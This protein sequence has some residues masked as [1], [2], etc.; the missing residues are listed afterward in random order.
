MPSPTAST[1]KRKAD[2]L[3]D[4]G[5]GR[6]AV[7]ARPKDA[8]S[9]SDN[10]TTM[11]IRV[12]TNV[13]VWRASNL[14]ALSTVA[15]LL[16][17]IATTRPT[18]EYT[19]SLCSDPGCKSPLVAADGDKDSK[20]LG[21]LG[22]HNGSIVYCGVVSETCAGGDEG[23]AAASVAGGM[24]TA[25]T[26]KRIVGKDGS[27]QLIP[28][29]AAEGGAGDDGRGFRKREMA[30]RDVKMHWT[31]AEVQEKDRKDD[32]D[33]RAALMA[34]LAAD[35]ERQESLLA[36]A[37]KNQEDL[38]VAKKNQED[39]KAA[40]KKNQEDL[41]VAEEKQKEQGRKNALMNIIIALQYLLCIALFLIAWLRA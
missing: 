37:K 40:A 18:V 17:V 28:A 24:G 12:R 4:S 10:T 5:G 2:V 34:A 22:L 15:D 32:R 29:E 14:T 33:G 23:A 35:K 19:T 7:I 25:S 30:L 16:A 11:L 1:K 39:L 21:E 36:V 9:V 13:G 27:I 41:E 20:T 8:T 6:P 3:G 31:L 38:A 26:M